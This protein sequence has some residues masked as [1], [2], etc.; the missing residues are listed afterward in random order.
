M[1]VLTGHDPSLPAAR[2]PEKSGSQPAQTPPR[3]ARAA[4][5][6][7]PR[8]PGPRPRGGAWGC[9]ALTQGVSLRPGPS[10]LAAQRDSIRFGCRFEQLPN[11]AHGDAPDTWNTTF[12]F[13]CGVTER[14]MIEATSCY[15]LVGILELSNPTRPTVPGPISSQLLG[16][17]LSVEGPS[18]AGRGVCKTSRVGAPHRGVCS[19]FLRM[20]RAKGGGGKRLG[21]HEVD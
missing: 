7:L 16:P 8:A 19:A 1:R 6:R 11:G 13:I 9:A 3:R 17:S 5:P 15:F 10:H 18:C 4:P 14:M 20:R 21:I 2:S 12:S